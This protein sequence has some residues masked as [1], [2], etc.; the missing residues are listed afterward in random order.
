MRRS[1]S[2]ATLPTRC[3][4]NVNC[5]NAQKLR[6]S[7]NVI[8]STLMD[9][10]LGLSSE[11][12]NFVGQPENKRHFL[13][14]FD[15]EVRDLGDLKKPKPIVEIRHKM[16]ILNYHLSRAYCRSHPTV[17]TP[18]RTA[19][20]RSP[21]QL[22]GRVSCSASPLTSR[23]SRRFSACSGRFGEAYIYRSDLGQGSGGFQGRARS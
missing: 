21:Q 14:D 10:V 6:W 17:Q 12:T 13:S 4:E 22:H 9:D 16:R 11:L 18:Q 8:S 2:R 1:R 15:I 20:Q 19:P 7:M 3:G 5:S 23:S